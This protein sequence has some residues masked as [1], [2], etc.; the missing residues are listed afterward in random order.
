MD[1]VQK[2]E[3]SF[4]ACVLTLFPQMFPGIL[5]HSLCGNALK[6]QLW[7][8]DVMDIRAFAKDKHATV[9]DLPFGGG[10][11]MVLRPDVIENALNAVKNRK[12]RILYLSP[13]GEKFTQD[14]ARDIAQEG[15]CTFLCGRYEGV[16]QRVI[17]KWAIAEVSLGD[18]IL[19]GGEPAAQ[20]ILD[21]IVRLLP[22]VMGNAN[23]LV[24]ESFED[25]L[26]EY[27]HYTRPNNWQGR[28]V[29]SVLLSGNHANI[30]QWRMRDREHVTRVRRPDMWERYLRKTRRK[31]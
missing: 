23:S 25:G 19:S 24:E 26:L 31:T 21:S 3:K 11:G 20:A 27:S 12:G 6:D 14:H 17:D 29:P 16:D 10:G 13:R 18:F 1:K 5:G 8:L 28:F 4:C 30:S 22:N 9:D 2:H 7:K 15:G